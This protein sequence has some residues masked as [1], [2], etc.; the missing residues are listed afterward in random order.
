VGE[1]SHIYCSIY[2]KKLS[3][4]KDITVYIGPILTFIER[5][6]K[7]NPVSIQKGIYI[8]PRRTEIQGELSWLFA[9]CTK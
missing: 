4:N 6:I 5:E 1:S 8:F 2:Q 9:W 7:V 3:Q